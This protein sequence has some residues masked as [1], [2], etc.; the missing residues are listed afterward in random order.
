AG[1]ESNIMDLPFLWDTTNLTI[2]H[3]V[4]DSAVDYHNKKSLIVTIADSGLSPVAVDK[5][6]F[7]VQDSS[8]AVAIPAWSNY[9]QHTMNGNALHLNLN[10]AFLFRNYLDKSNNG[11]TFNL[12]ID[13]I[14]DGAGNKIPAYTASFKV[15]YAS[16]KNG[17][18]WYDLKFGSS[19]GWYW[20]WDGFRCDTLQATQGQHNHI[21][22]CHL[23][24]CGGF[25]R[26]GSYYGNGDVTIATSWNVKRYP[27]LSFRA[28]QHVV[29]DGATFHLILAAADGSVYTYSLLKAGG[30][31]NELNLKENYTWKA[32]EVKAITINVAQLLKER[33]VPQEKIDKTTFTS[34]RFQRRGQQHNDMLD[35]DDFYIHGLPDDASKPDVMNLETYDVSG[36]AS[37]EFTAFTPDG[38][39]EWNVSFPDQHA[40]DLNKIRAKFTATGSRWIL[41]QSK[42]KAGNLN[43]GMW[44][45]IYGV[46][47]PP[48][49]PPAPKPEPPKPAAPAPAPAAAP[50]AQPAPAAKP[51]AAPAAAP[52]PA[53]A[54]QPAPAAAPAP[55]PAAKPAAAPAAKPAPAPA[56]AAKPAEA[57]KPA[58][59]AP[60]AAPAAKPAA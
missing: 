24:N 27:F 48:P 2:S 20:N 46:Y 36:V 15:D 32:G 1:V 37:V 38:K 50:A 43:G 16:D 45:P 5:L 56:P 34:V 17:P 41:C 33:G 29:R 10:H 57:P 60:A 35:I 4:R 11:D 14:E 9:L 31:S 53:P 6:K 47:T 49:P 26:N 18:N 3:A 19:V 39:P 30:E 54:A 52:A 28:N 44:L 23:P 40:I 7:F 42:D 59:P 21:Q 25:L 51:A 58:A 8:K 13:G 55:A 12:V 22:T